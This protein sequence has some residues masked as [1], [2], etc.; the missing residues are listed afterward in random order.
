MPYDHACFISYTHGQHTLMRSFVEQVGEALS[1]ELEAYFG[2]DAVYIDHQRLQ[3][4]YRYNEAL[5]SALC[6]SV[7]MVVL[8]TPTYAQS[9]Y[10]LREYTAMCGLEERRLAALAGH[11]PTRGL[12][13]PVVLRG[14]REQLPG[15]LKDHVH[16]LDFSQFSTAASRRI[17][18]NPRYVDSIAQVAAYM[19]DTAQA[20]QAVGV[21]PDDCG[22]FRLPPEDQV[23][24]LGGAAPQSFP[25]RGD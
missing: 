19:H 15:A 17:L 20:L 2:D 3:P 18:R 5:A 21:V 8:Y 4:G 25:G 10:C 22:R 11:D 23:V 16:Y 1:S 13:I 9:S 6:Q 14:R 7:C 12:I 24:D